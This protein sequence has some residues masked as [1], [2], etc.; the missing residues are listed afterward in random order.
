MRI[1]TAEKIKNT[2]ERLAIGANTVI[3]PDIMLK[4]KAGFR[5]ETGSLAKTALGQ[6]IENARI[7]RKE[8]LAI[9]QDTGLPLVFVELGQQICLKGCSLYDAVN[10]GIEAAY[11]KSSFRKSIIQDPMRKKKDIR[12]TPAIIYVD[13][14]PGDKIKLTVAPKGFGSENVSRIKMFDP[15]DGENKIIDFVVDTVVAAGPNAC[16]PF[17]I[18]VGI[19]GTLDKA[20]LLSKKA[21]CRNITRVKASSYVSMLESKVLKAVNKSGLGTMGFGGKVTALGVNILMHPTHIAGLPVAVSVGCHA[22]RSAL[23]TI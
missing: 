18:G 17:V 19:G 1:V 13:V 11:E 5:Q 8:K 4:L 3:R 21:L 23:A 9:C 20:V 15:T 2:V 14:V 12:F 16:P 6:I 10:D 7:A 22:T